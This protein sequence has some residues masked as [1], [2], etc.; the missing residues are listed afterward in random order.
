MRIACPICGSRDRREFWYLGAAQGR[1]GSGAG[2]G[3]WDAHLHL[4]D[5]PA[6]PRDEVWWH[7]AG[8]GAWLEV[9]RDTTTHAIAGVRLAGGGDAG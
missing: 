2:P 9:R 7:E 5:N 8:C 4:R 3:E 6:G 1:P